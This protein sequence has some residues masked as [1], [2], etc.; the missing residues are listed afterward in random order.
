MTPREALL[1]SVCVREQVALAALAAATGGTSLCSLSRAGSP[2]P[3]VKYHEGAASA[4]AEARRAVR[5][6]P[7]S[8]GAV[9]ETRAALGAIRARWRAQSATPGRAGPG[10][11]GYLAGGLDALDQLVDDDEGRARDAEN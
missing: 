7:E 5:N 9:R 4:L 10:W 3:A 8:P 2:V 11:A 6:V 1:E